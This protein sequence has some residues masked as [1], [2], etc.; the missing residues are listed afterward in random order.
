MSGVPG[1]GASGGVTTQSDTTEHDDCGT[2]QPLL[3]YYRSRER[4][5]FLQETAGS[6]EEEANAPRWAWAQPL[7]LL[8]Q[9]VDKLR[10]EQR[11]PVM[12]LVM[13][14]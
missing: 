6:T 13:T 11:R 10:N 3:G 7:A 1:A 5:Y 4:S 2:V 8:T 9:R 14:S 12:A